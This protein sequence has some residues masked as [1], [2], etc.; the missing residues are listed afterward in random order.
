VIA[1]GTQQDLAFLV[2]HRL[3]T[4]SGEV[5]LLVNRAE[6]EVEVE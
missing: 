6:V 4:T 1:P 3:M 2:A 5:W